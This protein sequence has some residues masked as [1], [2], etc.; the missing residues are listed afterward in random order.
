MEIITAERLDPTNLTS[1]L[2]VEVCM[3]FP[4]LVSFI[5]VHSSLFKTQITFLEFFEVLL[6]SAEV[7]CS[8]VSEGHMVSDHD[9]AGESIMQTTNTGSQEVRVRVN[10]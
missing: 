3:L 10:F 7:K 5:N 2:D 9:E 8:Q 6:G 1:C 4:P